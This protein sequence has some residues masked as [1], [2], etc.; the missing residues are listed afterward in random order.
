M[1]QALATR[2]RTRG[3]GSGL[4]REEM[5]PGMVKDRAL[6]NAGAP[7][8]SLILRLRR[9]VHSI[10][11]LA[12]LPPQPRDQER[13]SWPSLP[14]LGAGGTLI[15]PLLAPLEYPAPAEAPLI[16]PGDLVPNPLRL[17]LDCNASLDPLVLAAQ[18]KACGR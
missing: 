7:W 14:G 4:N 6:G 10:P 16:S 11:A 15:L 8:R 1:N 12:P 9:S 17:S 3:L 18:P 5:A 13:P 2:G